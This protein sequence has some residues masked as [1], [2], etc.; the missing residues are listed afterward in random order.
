MRIISHLSYLPQSNINDRLRAYSSTQE[1]G[2]C[3]CAKLLIVKL[4]SFFYHFQL[5]NTIFWMT[6]WIDEIHMKSTMRPTTNGIH[7]YQPIQFHCSTN[8]KIINELLLIIS[9]HSYSTKNSIVI[10]ESQNSKYFF[11]LLSTRITLSFEYVRI[12]MEMRFVA[13]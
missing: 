1:C 2:F 10:N 9:L 6:R 12:E 5:P 3:A 8:E 7:Q 13:Y 4:C 11:F